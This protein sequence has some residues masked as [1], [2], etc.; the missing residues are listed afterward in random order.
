[1]ARVTWLTRGL[2]LLLVA[3]LL[4]IG[5]AV[6]NELTTDPVKWFDADNQHIPFGQGRKP[7]DHACNRSVAEGSEFNNQYWEK[8]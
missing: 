6:A 2:P 1:M 7:G 5:A 8:P 4:L 3:C